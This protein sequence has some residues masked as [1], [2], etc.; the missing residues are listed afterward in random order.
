[1]DNNQTGNKTDDKND[2]IE[3]LLSGS[4]ADVAAHAQGLRDLHLSYSVPTWNAEMARSG[5]NVIVP[6]PD[7]V[8]EVSAMLGSSDEMKRERAMAILTPYAPAWHLLCKVVLDRIAPG[9]KAPQALAWF[10]ARNRM[11]TESR[12]KNTAISPTGAKGVG[13]VLPSTMRDTIA[14]TKGYDLR[15]Y[16]G[17]NDVQ[18]V[19]NALN[20]TFAVMKNFIVQ[21]ASWG[22]PN[23]IADVVNTVPQP[24]RLLI[25]AMYYYHNGG[26]VPCPDNPKLTSGPK[27]IKFWATGLGSTPSYRTFYKRLLREEASGFVRAWKML[28]EA[29]PAALSTKL[30]SPVVQLFKDYQAGRLK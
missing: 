11:W 19:L 26:K 13:Q 3:G 18:D 12:F 24:V 7:V 2:V 22:V 30:W 14:T 25:S 6:A 15:S 17:T 20:V 29:K 21:A 28:G 10:I 4:G 1:M 23:H 27:A 8:A 16:A 5:G 9:S